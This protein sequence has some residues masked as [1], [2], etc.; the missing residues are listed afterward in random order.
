MGGQTTDMGDVTATI[1]VESPDLPL[2][3][4]VEY[5]ESA[6]VKPVSGAGATPEL[7]TYLFTVRTADFDRFETG[8][9]RDH[10]IDSYKRVIELGTEAMYRFEYS[11]DATV[12]SG[13]V[14]DVDGI[15]LEW[16]ND[17]TAWTVRVWLPER[18]ALA[19]LWEYASEHGIEFSLERITASTPPG[20]SAHGL[21]E[22]Q[23]AAIL[24]ALEMGYFEE[25]RG[26]T[27]SEVAAELGISQPAAGGLLRRGLRQLVVNTLAVDAGDPVDTN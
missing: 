1:R 5:D 10:T 4:T 27:M 12:F 18:Q 14:A 9:E 26:A 24:R 7:G 19:S 25:P 6:T 23:R 21:T 8:L 16:V 20:E 2:T 22:D 3:K 13:A 11:A 15:S 17:G